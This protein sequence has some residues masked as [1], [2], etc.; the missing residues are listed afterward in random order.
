MYEVLRGPS[1]L[2]YGGADYAVN[3][4][5]RE[6]PR[7]PKRPVSGVMDLQHATGSEGETAAGYF[8]YGM[9]NGR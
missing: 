1:T 2:L 7:V 4:L 8:N 5:G 6:L 9:S 3:V